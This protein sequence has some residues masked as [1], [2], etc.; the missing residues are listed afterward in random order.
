MME[1]CRA[2]FTWAPFSI[3]YSPIYTYIGVCIESISSLLASLAS[4]VYGLTFQFDGKS[5]RHYY[6]FIE[7]E[8][9][10]VTHSAF[11]RTYI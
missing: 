11:A 6:G 8:F 9:R 3:L 7:G 10:R 4:A 1:A 2:W 5:L